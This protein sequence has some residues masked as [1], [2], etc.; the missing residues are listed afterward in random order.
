V[1]SPTIVW[2]QHPDILAGN[3]RELDEKIQEG[4]GMIADLFAAQMQAQAAG[5]APWTDQSGAARGGLRGFAE[6]AATQVVI[7]L[8]HSVHYG[9][10]LELGTRYMA[11][12]PI[13]VPTLEANYGAIMAAVRQLLA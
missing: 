1:G 3:I 5:S 6:K 9:V 8:V 11:P 7:Y 4:I 2:E 12:R 10:Y 13:I